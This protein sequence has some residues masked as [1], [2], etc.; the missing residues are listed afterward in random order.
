MKILITGSNGQ[1]GIELLNQ[2]NL[3][4]KKETFV[5]EIMDLSEILND[6]NS[7]AEIKEIATNEFNSLNVSSNINWFSFS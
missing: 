7:D 5:K 3:V 1:L 4:N 2:I 6:K